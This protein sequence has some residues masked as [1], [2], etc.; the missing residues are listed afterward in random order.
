MRGQYWILAAE[1][2]MSTVSMQ[3]NDKNYII[4]TVAATAR[5][6]QRTTLA[7]LT[8]IAQERIRAL[9]CACVELV[10]CGCGFHFIS[11]HHLLEPLNFW[12]KWQANVHSRC[13]EGC[14]DIRRGG[15]LEATTVT[16]V[17]TLCSSPTYMTITLHLTTLNYNIWSFFTFEKKK[18]VIDQLHVSKNM[19]GTLLVVLCNTRVLACTKV[20]PIFHLFDLV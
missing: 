8:A 6:T 11:F 18:H 19:Y 14:G 4:K 7:S 1:L 17:T 10:F 2:E 5:N 20:W 15:G 12:I 3:L 13:N 9:W 16:G